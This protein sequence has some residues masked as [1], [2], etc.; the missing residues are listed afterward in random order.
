MVARFHICTPDESVT[1]TC[2][3]QVPVGTLHVD[4]EPFFT[5]TVNMTRS[6]AE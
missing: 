2:G 3:M 6:P 1:R 4:V 5:D